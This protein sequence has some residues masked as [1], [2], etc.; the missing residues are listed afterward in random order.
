MSSS[1]LGLVPV[2]TGNNWIQW[3]DMMK[4]YLQSQGLWLYIEGA[5]KIPED[6]PSTANA[7]EKLLRQNQI[8]EWHKADQ[9]AVGA[10]TLKIAPSLKTYIGEETLMKEFSELDTIIGQVKANKIEM[11]EYV[12]TLMVLQTLPKKFKV[13]AQT[14]LQD[15]QMKDSATLDILK[16]KVILEW[17]R[18]SKLKALA[19]WISTVKPKGQ[20]PTYQN[21]KGS[22][23]RPFNQQ[24]R[25]QPSTSSMPQPANTGNQQQKP[26][27]KKKRGGVKVKARIA[28]AQLAAAA[29]SSITPDDSTMDIDTPMLPLPQD[30]P[31]PQQAIHST[32]EIGK[33]GKVVTHYVRSDM[34]SHT[35]SQG[36]SA[37][38]WVKQ[39]VGKENQSRY[40]TY[41][42]AR[43]LCDDL[44][45][46]KTAEMIRRLEELIISDSHW[47]PQTECFTCS[48]R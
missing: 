13:V 17:E 11:P 27:N 47:C 18:Q 16:K 29:Y 8:L 33:G 25:S 23:H 19:N 37:H 35:Y 9:M 12:T 38:K 46:P 1:A 21:Q 26:F 41:Q 10:I 15:N 48:I 2:L 28:A 3:S 31:P 40:S 6:A 22:S 24:Q 5:I 30:P 20:N 36:A 42:D 32:L 45:A 7:A 44:G 14:F 34:P 39:L 43:D 4:A